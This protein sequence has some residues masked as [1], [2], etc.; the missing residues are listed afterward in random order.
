MLNNGYEAER[1]QF[2]LGMKEYLQAKEH[3]TSWFLQYV[4]DENVP[5]VL[6]VKVWEDTA[7]ELLPVDSWISGNPFHGADENPFDYDFR[8]RGEVIWFQDLV[9]NLVPETEEYEALWLWDTDEEILTDIDKRFPLLK[10]RFDAIFR[11][12]KA[13]FT[14]DW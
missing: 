6:R 4:R 1:N 8:G 9:E 2:H 10:E 14:F 11:N 13:A 12:G 5:L 3:M 7:K